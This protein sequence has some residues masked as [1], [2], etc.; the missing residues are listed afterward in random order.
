V[1]G[2]GKILLVVVTE[3]QSCRR[4]VA[5]LIN[6]ENWGYNGLSGPFGQKKPGRQLPLCGTSAANVP[7]I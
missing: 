1:A 2:K 4:R 5:K 6:V 7:F 3:W